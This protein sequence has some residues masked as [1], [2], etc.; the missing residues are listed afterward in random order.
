[1]KNLILTIVAAVT[2]MS[3]SPED[4]MLE[5]FE[6]GYLNYETTVNGIEHIGCD[7]LWSFNNNIVVVQDAPP[8]GESVSFS[9]PFTFDEDTLRISQVNGQE[10]VWVEYAYGVEANGDLTLILITGD[11]SVVYSLRR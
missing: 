4:R 5:T 7:F 10:I 6:G 11:Y 1:M 3:C 9:R 2:L 8:C